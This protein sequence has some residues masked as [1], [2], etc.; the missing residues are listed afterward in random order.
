MKR[1]NSKFYNSEYVSLEHIRD[2]DQEITIHGTIHGADEEFIKKLAEEF[3]YINVVESVMVIV[4]PIKNRK[5][6]DEYIKNHGYYLCYDKYIYIT[7]SI[8]GGYLYSGWKTGRKT[9]ILP[10]DLPDTYVELHNYKKRGYLET[11]GVTDV[12]YKQSPFHNHAFK[13]DFL[14]ISYSGEIVYTHAFSDNDKYDEYIFGND[15]VP[16]IDAI[17][18]NNPELEQKVNEIKDKMVEQYNAFCDHEN[19]WDFNHLNKVETFSEL[20]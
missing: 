3:P 10:S 8:P 17:G 14:Y 19:K 13:D 2:V 18:R 16:V 12:L 11:A 1:F 7:H 5:E 20:L 9:K 15:I 4:F 6:L